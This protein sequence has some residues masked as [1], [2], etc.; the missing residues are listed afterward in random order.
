MNTESPV[1]LLEQEF[2]K[3]KAKNKSYSLRSYAKNLGVSPA[4][5]SQILSGKKTLTPKVMSIIGPNLNLEENYLEKLVSKQVDEKKSRHVK[6]LN[7]E[8]MKIIK[9]ETFSVISDWYHYAILELMN[10]DYYEMNPV[11]IAKKISISESEA[12][13]AIENLLSVRL[14]EYNEEGNLIFT[15][16]FTVIDDYQFSSVAMRERQKQILKLSAEK[17][18]KIDISKRDHGSITMTIDEDL[19]PVIKE[20]IREFRRTLGNY[21]AKNSKKS[22]HVYEIQ[23]SCF[24]LTNDEN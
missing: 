5:L 20:K 23:M 3:R 17:I 22:S 1:Y 4:V 21:I 12:A 18:D 16:S 15:D 19:L 11:W 8:Q 9:M 14:L 10:L 7:K 2:V 24:P 13:K 6:N